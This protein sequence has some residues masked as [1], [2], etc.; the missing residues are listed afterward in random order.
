L[1]AEDK[2]KRYIMRIETTI[3]RAIRMQ[4]K[5][6]DGCVFKKGSSSFYIRNSVLRA[7]KQDGVDLCSLFPNIY[8]I[9][10][11]KNVNT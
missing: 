11:P 8:K 10:R 9:Y 6:Y 3:L 7:L 4:S 5:K 2:K 1:N